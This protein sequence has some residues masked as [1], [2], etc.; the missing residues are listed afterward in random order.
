MN[1]LEF[2]YQRPDKDEVLTRLQE[3]LHQFEQAEDYAAFFNTFQQF[4]ELEKH[5]Q[6]QMQ[7]ANIRHSIDTRDEFYTQECDYFDV[8][9]PI[10][11]NAIHAIDQV[12]LNS[13][14]RQQLENDVPKTWFM[15]HEFNQK[16]MSE[17]IIEDL[18]EEN[19]LASRYQN[20]I[21][22]AQIDFN[23]EVH[24]LASIEKYMSDPDRNMR[25]QAHKAYWGWFA[26]HEQE[27]GDIFDQLVQVRTKI[28][29]KMGYETFTPFGYLRMLRLDYDRYDVEQYRQNVLEDVVPVA[30]E[31][32][33]AQAKRHGYEGP[34]LPAWD[35]KITFESGNPQ[36]KYDE[37]ELV[38]RALQMYREL[39][40]QTGTFFEGMV[41]QNLMD[42]NAKPGKA[43]GGYCE[44]LPDYGVPF[45][46]ANFNGTSADIETLTHEAGHGFQAWLSRNAFPY[47][48]VW[49]TNESAE[50]DSMGMEFLTWPWMELFFEEDTAKYYY[51]HLEGAVK[52]LGY[53]VL[54]D[55][56]QHEVYD[57]PTW[58]H[59]QRMACWRE[60]EQQYLPQK[61]YQDIDVLERGGWWMRQLH[62]FMMPFYYIDYTLAQVVALQIWSRMQRHDETVFDDYVAMAK[63][64]GTKTFKELVTISK[65]IVP[66]E[67]G[68]L[69]QTMQDVK[70]WFEAHDVEE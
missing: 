11:D 5:F 51:T 58:N 17:A 55:H 3:L 65:N 47:D 40:E 46:F 56:F 45:I 36:P 39:S 64:G 54:V 9:S 35:E 30:M 19:K 2:K 38:R 68:C 24:T 53:G 26:D 27:I 69:K 63:C 31:L 57:H 21:A 59:D 10:V 15:I 62:I 29:N 28:A 48:L 34:T 13:P 6:T 66:F 20:V 60:L 12:V 70:A 18:Q 25:K 49:P 4:I 43:A 1:F 44:T 50:I 23:D 32:Y 14:Y 52:F 61:D 37:P 67:K 42:L 41:D 22:S 33:Q 8:I 7:L 16:V